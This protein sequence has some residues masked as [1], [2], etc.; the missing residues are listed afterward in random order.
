MNEAATEDRATRRT[1]LRTL[2]GDASGAVADLGVLV[3]LAAALILVN[4]LDAAA[5]FVGAGLLAVASGLA[6]RIP[7]PVQPL[8]ALTAVAVARELAP[9]V[10]HAAGL[11]LA[12]FLLLLSIG[13]VA[14]LV[15][16][17][18]VK[19][20]VRALQLGVGTLLIVAAGRL[21]IDPPSVFVGTPESPWPMVL[22]AVAFAGVALAARR[23][24]Y[25][26]ALLLFAAGVSVTL[27]VASPALGT[28]ELRL[29]ALGLPPAGAF[30]AAFFLLVVPQLPL[31]FGN[32][33]VAVNDLAHE[34]FGA[35]AD[36]VT[37][38]RVCLSAGAGNVAAALLGGMPMCHG[39]GGL[40]AHV[41][42][43]ARMARMNLVLGGA[44][45]VLG[46]V[47]AAH[48]PAVLGLVPVWV[49]SAFLAYAGFR[50]AWLVA[51]L[52][53]PS[54][55]IALV[56]GLLGAWLGNL[57]VTAGLALLL[58]HGFRRARRRFA[59]GA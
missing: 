50:H 36:R 40:T 17:L 28:P 2:V 42:L 26:G 49:L 59:V 53:G 7:F 39:A 51:D 54:L 16:R 21:V 29:P 19:P 44:F 46:L 38:S 27:V 30:A 13:H 34:Y 52:R 15:A 43:G 48:I 9:D 35:A 18:F 33:V 6:F 11:E 22:A 56:A 5:V 20:V 45:L 55:A 24:R 41:R 32:A 47:F 57:A 12:A 58:E 8:K 1:P 10:I 23:R 25:G 14:D 3:P 4:G 31:T 37:P